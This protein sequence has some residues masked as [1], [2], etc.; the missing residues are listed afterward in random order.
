MA[1][2]TRLK[3]GPVAVLVL[4]ALL[5]LLV[6]KR[7]HLTAEEA[8][9]DAAR[10]GVKLEERAFRDEFGQVAFIAL[11]AL[12]AFVMWTALR[13]KEGEDKAVPPAR[14]SSASGT[15]GPTT[16]AQSSSGPAA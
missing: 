2:G 10:V 12:F 11:V 8:A 16:P 3:I 5:T 1:K 13:A 4:L 14:E 6:V 9:E 15:T 7:R